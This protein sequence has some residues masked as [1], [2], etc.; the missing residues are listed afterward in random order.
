MAG[1]SRTQVRRLEQLY[2]ERVQ[3]QRALAGFGGQEIYGGRIRRQEREV[4]QLRRTSQ[5]LAKAL[6]R[7]EDR[8]EAGAARGTKAGIDGRT[9]RAGQRRKANR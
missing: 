3:S 7:I 4:A 1:M 8:I 6:E 2:A 5:R 9:T